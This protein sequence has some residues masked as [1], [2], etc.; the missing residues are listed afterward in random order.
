MGGAVFAIIF[1]L[2]SLGGNFDAI[3]EAVAE[4]KTKIRLQLRPDQGHGLGFLPGR[5]RR[6]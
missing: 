4:Q 5:V 6:G 1:I 3:H 2:W